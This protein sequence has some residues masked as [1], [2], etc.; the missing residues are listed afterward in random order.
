MKPLNSKFPLL[1]LN[2]KIDAAALN[3]RNMVYYNTYS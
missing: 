3:Q 1:D 2:K